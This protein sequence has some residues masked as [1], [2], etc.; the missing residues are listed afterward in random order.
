MNME[1]AQ[2]LKSRAQTLAQQKGLDFDL[3]FNV[4]DHKLPPEEAQREQQQRRER[5]ER[6]QQAQTLAQQ[7]GLDLGLAFNVVDGELPPEE[8]RRRQREKD[9]LKVKLKI[10]TNPTDGLTW[11]TKKKHRH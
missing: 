7:E 4:V 9:N 11:A 2:E 10:A 3:A 6:R 1:E 5:G 8:A